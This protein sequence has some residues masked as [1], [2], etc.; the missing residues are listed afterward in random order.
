MSAWFGSY[1]MEK[2]VK[3]KSTVEDVINYLK[4][5]FLEEVRCAS[6]YLAVAKGR[7]KNFGKFADGPVTSDASR[8]EIHDAL[9]FMDRFVQDFLCLQISRQFPEVSVLLEE[10]STVRKLFSPT[11]NL[12]TILIDPID[13]TKQFS[14]GGPDYAILITYIFEGSIKYCVG[15]YPESGTLFESYCGLSGDT[16]CKSRLKDLSQ[17]ETVACHYRITKDSNRKWQSALERAG[18]KLV[19][20]GNGF[21]TNLTAARLVIEGKAEAFVCV[22]TAAHDALAP[23]ELIRSAGGV[24]KR[25]SIKTS[26]SLNNT[27]DYSFYDIQN[28]K[29]GH[30]SP[31]VRLIGARD[32]TTINA[33]ESILEFA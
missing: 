14:I 33:L 26:W 20:N 17:V 3:S 12:G 23:I 8:N 27:I 31:R 15:L 19:W 28:S 30:S 10:E 18:K 16:V 25:Y 32:D 29:V 6:A 4:T 5:E 13:G 11:G 7:E 22:Y 2:F 9:T 24:A 1:I 21:H